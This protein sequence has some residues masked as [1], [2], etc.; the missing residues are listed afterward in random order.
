MYILHCFEVLL[1]F[2]GT[3]IFGINGFR[4]VPEQRESVASAH[5]RPEHAF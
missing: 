1:E 2:I 4:P 3:T 5:C